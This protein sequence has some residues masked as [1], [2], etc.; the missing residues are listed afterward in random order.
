MRTVKLCFPVRTASSLRGGT[1]QVEGH[2]L[3]LSYPQPSS[4]PFLRKHF[5]WQELRRTTGRAGPFP[6]PLNVWRG[7]KAGI[8]RTGPAQS[9][10]LLQHALRRKGTGLRAVGSEARSSRNLHKLLRPQPASL[11]ASHR[12]DS[13]V[14]SKICG[15]K[16]RT[17]AVKIP[18]PKPRR[19]LISR[20]TASKTDHF[21]DGFSRLARKGN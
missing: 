3:R 15:L 8:T 18:R 1:N 12:E 13:D 9:A 21:E 19:R 4:F 16:R 5:N 6:R 2:D 7:I 17:D 11:R 14:P 20:P 10:S